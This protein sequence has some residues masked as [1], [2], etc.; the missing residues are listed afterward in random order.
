MN[1]IPLVQSVVLNRVAQAV[2]ALVYRSISLFMEMKVN[3]CFLEVFIPIRDIISAIIMNA[4][5]T[6][7]GHYFMLH[8]TP[9]SHRIP[10]LVNPHK[11]T[12]L[13][14]HHL[15]NLDNRL[16]LNKTTPLSDYYYRF[17]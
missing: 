17:H 2:I 4:V 8:I 7:I 11:H 1:R 5:L 15:I 14:R 6:D 16:V 10:L 13:L 12:I 9:Y 3:N